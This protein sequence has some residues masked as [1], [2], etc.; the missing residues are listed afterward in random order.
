MPD[1]LIY[2]L[3]VNIALLL[4]CLGYYLVL[5]RLT[6]YT[7]NR[8]Y[9][10]TAI[11]FSSLYPLIDLSGI[12]QRHEKLV[13]PI[14]LIVITLNTKATQ[15]AQPVSQT[16][17]WQWLVWIFWTG[18]AIMATRLAIQFIS[19]WKIYRRS[20][21]A[22]LHNYNVRII[23]EEANP[24]SFWQSIFINPSHH[25]DDELRSIIA[26]EQVHVSQWHT[27]D[28]LLAEL[29]LVFYWFNPGV[30]LM[31]KAVA[32]NLE[33]ITDRQ[34]LRQ[35]IDAKS[36]Q[37]SLLYASFNTSP[38]A[39][40]NHFNISTIKKRIMM[41]NSKRSSAYSLTRYGFIAP[42]VLVLLLAF[43]T[44]KAA[45]IKKSLNSAKNATSK[46]IAQISINEAD[47]ISKEDKNILTRAK[48]ALV[49]YKAELLNPDTTI[50]LNNISFTNDTPKYKMTTS[51]HF[52]GPDSAYYIL[53]G[54]PMGSILSS[55]INP[56]DIASIHIVGPPSAAKLFGP[57]ATAGAVLFITKDA[58]NTALNKE[59]IEKVLAIKKTGSP[60]QTGIVSVKP[61]KGSLNSITIKG[62]T[63]SL[64]GKTKGT[65]TSVTITGTPDYASLPIKRKVTGVKINGVQDTTVKDVVVVGY[66]ISTKNG[67]IINRARINGVPAKITTSDQVIINGHMS[68]DSLGKKL[69]NLDKL[70]NE[71][72]LYV[73]DGKPASSINNISPN[74]IEN[75]QVLKELSAISLYGEKGKNGVILITTKEGANASKEK[76]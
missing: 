1:I 70:G 40:V 66:A 28:I 6:F 26:H 27:L 58:E 51:M 24:F 67:N 57:K 21:P 31:K 32:E 16:N 76:N 59:I 37:Y 43:G 35:G 29:S 36:Y 5:R 18:V 52:T 48:E 14:Q 38:N 53:N 9:L 22:N 23:H 25:A 20:K 75:V 44:S 12:M 34:I 13:E 60:S 33:F 49:S 62:T 17:Y 11:L 42:A 71:E 4:F 7:L 64:F 41:M 72:P 8:V 73:I 39:M 46:V 15:L 74:S 50:K 19:L 63:D 3:K 68:Y 54:K 45:F 2:L 65:V 30:W 56:N 69:S 55:T 47:K 10:I 61:P